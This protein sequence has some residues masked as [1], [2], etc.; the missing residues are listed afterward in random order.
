MGYL[1]VLKVLSEVMGVL[2]MISSWLIDEFDNIAG[3]KDNDDNT[4]VADYVT[5][6][7]KYS[8]PI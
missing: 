4:L 5:M 6:W 3:D 2:R 8:C 1:G 7:N